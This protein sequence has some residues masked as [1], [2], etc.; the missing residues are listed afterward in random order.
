[1]MGSN[2]RTILLFGDVTDSWTEGIDYVYRQTKDKPWLRL[3]LDELFSVIKAEAKDMDRVLRNS[4]QNTSSFQE[5]ADRYRHTGDEF[6]MASAIIVYAIRAVVLLE[7]VFQAFVTV[8]IY[9]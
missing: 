8:G 7:Y 2:H 5:L 3:F 1:M 6:G 9:H 4:L